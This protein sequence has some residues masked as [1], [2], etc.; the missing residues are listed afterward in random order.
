MK[1]SIIF[2]TAILTLLFASSAC[3]KCVQCTEYNPAGKKELQYRE[4]CGKKDEIDDYRIEQENNV[5]P[6]NKV[7]CEERKTTLF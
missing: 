3:R 6:N 5:N 2:Y 4:T 1:R 7:K